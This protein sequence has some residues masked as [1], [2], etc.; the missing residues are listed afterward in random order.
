MRGHGREQPHVLGR[1]GAV[2]RVGDDQRAH[3]HSVRAQGHR[4]GG[5]HRHVLQ[6]SRRLAARAADQLEP[7][8]SQRARDQAGIGGSHETSGQARQ[9]PLGGGDA[10]GAV[11]PPFPFRRERDQRSLRVEESHGVAHHLLHDVVELQGAREDVGELL[12][13]EELG[14]TAVELVRRPPPVALAPIEAPL[15]MERSPAEP[16][17]E[18]QDQ[19]NENERH[20]WHK[21][22][23][24]LT[25]RIPTSRFGYR[26]LIPILN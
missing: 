13:G 18:E 3:D 1:E 2:S 26:C 22:N 19:G 21:N 11:P 14:E 23:D 5:V 17:R 16:A 6:E 4:S 8:A 25:L 7:L 12:E 20:G 24:C 10:E 9:C 15:E